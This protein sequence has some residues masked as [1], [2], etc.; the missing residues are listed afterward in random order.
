M[1]VNISTLVEH[2]E[3]F[4]VHEIFY[5]V[6]PYSFMVLMDYFAELHEQFFGVL[7]VCMEVQ[8]FIYADLTKR[9]KYNPEE[10]DSKFTC[11]ISDNGNVDHL[12]V[13]YTVDE[14]KPD[15]TLGL[16]EIDLSLDEEY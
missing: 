13:S 1:K 2:V 11:L 12:E 14:T 16:L 8:E 3:K 10:E 6:R 7:P 4:N 5:H 15:V 9:K